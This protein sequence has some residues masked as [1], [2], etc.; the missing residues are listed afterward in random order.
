LTKSP[1]KEIEQLDPA[2]DTLPMSTEDPTAW[3]GDPIAS[4]RTGAGNVYINVPPA[5]RDVVVISLDVAPSL[6][7][8]DRY[9]KINLEGARNLHRGLAAAIA[10]IQEHAGGESA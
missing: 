1:K 6:T 10:Q 2:W 9:V 5:T 3:L 8:E 7:G 4:H